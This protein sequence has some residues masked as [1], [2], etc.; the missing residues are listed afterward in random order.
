M[1][2]R[3]PRHILQTNAAI[4]SYVLIIALHPEIQRK[5]Q[6][7]VDA[8]LDGRLPTFKDF[9]KIPY[10]D[11][12]VGEVFR[13]SPITPLGVP[14]VARRDDY[15]DGHFISKGTMVFGNIW[16]LLRDENIYGVNTDKFIPERFITKD[17]KI[18][19]TMDY[20]LYDTA[21][22]WGRRICPGKGG[23]YQDRS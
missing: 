22:G 5:G 17:G 2:S 7:A 21:F 19:A 13:W 1:I 11:A 15:Y 3:T 9:G 4:W 6:A 23:V 16:A 8:A 18:D 10:V 20:N 12:I 14:H